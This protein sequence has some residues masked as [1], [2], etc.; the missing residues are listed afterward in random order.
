MTTSAAEGDEGEYHRTSLEELK[1]LISFNNVEVRVLDDL[2]AKL[3]IIDN[4][5]AISG[6]ANLTLRGMRHNIEHVEVKM[7]KDSINEF[8]KVF[9]E[10][11]KDAIIL[12]Y[13]KKY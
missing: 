6:S 4:K 5:Y 8:N 9:N 2:H 13:V 10:M 7:D 3:Y 1:K 11:W 12:G